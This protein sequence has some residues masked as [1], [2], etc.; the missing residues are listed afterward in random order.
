MT[1][2][3]CRD[4]VGASRTAL[5]GVLVLQPEPRPSQRRASR[6]PESS[7]GRRRASPGKNP[8]AGHHHQLA[9]A[10]TRK[11]APKPG[12]RALV[13]AS[14]LWCP[15]TRLAKGGGAVLPNLQI[16]FPSYATLASKFRLTLLGDSNRRQSMAIDGNR[17]QSMAID[18]NW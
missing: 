2:Q 3:V 6:V 17:W 16:W 11:L 1:R 9:H 18:G 8:A 5:H 14:R 13:T 15:R 10:S 7:G 4:T 12:A